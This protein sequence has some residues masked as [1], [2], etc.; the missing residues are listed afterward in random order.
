MKNFT[1]PL[2]GDCRT[3]SLIKNPAHGANILVAYP[4][5]E[6]LGLIGIKEETRSRRRQNYIWYGHFIDPSNV[7]PPLFLLDPGSLEEG[8]V[9]A[10]LDLAS[11]Q[12]KL[13]TR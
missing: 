8:I 4:I 3:E 6:N 7:L 9:A 11:H 5:G 2:E 12:K 10:K 13:A 1:R